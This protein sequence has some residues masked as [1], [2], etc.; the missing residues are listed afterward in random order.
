MTIE[1][2]AKKDVLEIHNLFRDTW[3]ATYPN[4]EY[5][6]SV[7][8]IEHHFGQLDQAALDKRADYIGTAVVDE[9]QFYKIARIDEKIVGI[10]FG[11]TVEEGVYLKSLYVLPTYQGQGIGS[12]L[13]EVFKRWAGQGRPVYVSVAIYNANAIAFYIAKG[14]VDTGKRFSEERFR[15]KSGSLIPEVEMKFEW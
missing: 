6:I 13:F 4:E 11:K 2:P 10:V 3:L 1:S 12:A 7:E 14:F 15:M 5:G 9:Q 8:D